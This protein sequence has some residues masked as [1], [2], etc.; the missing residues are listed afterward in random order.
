MPDFKFQ[1]LDGKPVTPQALAGRVAILVF[2]TSDVDRFEQCME[3]LHSV[4][5]VRQPVKNNPNLAFYAVCVDPPQ[6]KSSDLQK[7]I[8]EDGVHL[9]VLRDP[10]QASAVFNPSGLPMLVVLDAKGTVQH[11]DV[12]RALRLADELPRK[13]MKVLA[14][15]DIYQERQK[16]YLALVERLRAEARR[17]RFPKSRRRAR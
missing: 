2:W 1:D 17:K 7:A 5:L 3:M 9:P 10:E 16:A 6:I 12:G 11:F 14:G 15:E 4:E 13:L 8:E